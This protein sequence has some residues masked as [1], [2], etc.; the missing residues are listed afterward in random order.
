M[1]SNGLRFS[2]YLQ[3]GD[4]FS[5]IMLEAETVSGNEKL[6]ISSIVASGCVE[7]TVNAKSIYL[8]RDLDL[9]LILKN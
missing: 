9:E 2:M 1:K 8:M 5:L 6:F 3:A 7:K 4:L